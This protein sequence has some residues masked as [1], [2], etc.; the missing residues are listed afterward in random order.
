MWH[1]THALTE[2]KLDKR[3]NIAKWLK[4][5]G[6]NLSFFYIEDQ[7]LNFLK[8]RREKYTLV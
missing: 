2:L 3:I 8:L 6:L 1:A 7:N 4:H 5:R